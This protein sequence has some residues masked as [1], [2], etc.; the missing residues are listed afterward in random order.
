MTTPVSQ[1][2]CAIIQARMGS[3]RLS[4][5]VM[6]MINNEPMLE[7]V[8]KQVKFSKLVKK[9]VVATTNLRE[10]DVIFRY[11]KKNKILCFRGSTHDL[12]DRYYKCAKKYHCDPIVRIA[13][14]SPLIDPTVIDKVIEKFF[15]DHPNV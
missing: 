5:K 15:L 7:H 8:I 4:G 11:C 1:K 12:L 2:I 10:D 6:K 3:K 13:S 14:D 9:I